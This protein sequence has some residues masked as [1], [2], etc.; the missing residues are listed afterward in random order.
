MPVR[1][2]TLSEKQLRDINDLTEDDGAIG[3]TQDDNIPDL[4]VVA[5][6][7]AVTQIA[8]TYAGGG[9]GSATPADLAD[10]STY[11]TDFGAL[12]DNLASLF[13]GL[14]AAGVDVAAQKVQVDLLITDHAAV[15]D[16]LREVADKVNVILADVR[17]RP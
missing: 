2:K 12:E 14:N 13:E 10:G 1:Q 8:Y 17:N 11:A 3:G 4:A 9:T 15:R 7:V 5:A 16:G 6:P